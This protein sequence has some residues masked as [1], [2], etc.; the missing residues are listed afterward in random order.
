MSTLIVTDD[1][2]G[3]GR[4]LL[5]AANATTLILKD[6]NVVSSDDTAIQGGSN[7]NTVDVLVAGNIY[8]DLKGIG[9]VP[10]IA[11]TGTQTLNVMATGSVLA[12]EQAIEVIASQTT[13]TEISVSNAG[14][15]LSQNQEAV[16]I[17]GAAQATFANT[18]S[19]TGT[20]GAVK[21]T[22]LD[23]NFTNTGTVNSLAQG[24]GSAN[25]AVSFTNVSGG[26]AQFDNS[27]TV[28]GQFYSL[29]AVISDGFIGTNSGTMNG[30]IVINANIAS[31]FTNSG[32]IFGFVSLSNSVSGTFVFQNFG[33][34]SGNVN[35][36]ETSNISNGGTIGGN[37]T[38]GGED[39]VYRAVGAGVVAGTVSGGAGNDTIIGGSEADVLDGSFENDMV[40]GMAGD[41]ELYGGDGDDTLRGG[42]GEDTLFGGEGED[43][44]AGNSGNDIMTGEAGDDR[45]RGDGGD[46]TLFGGDDNDR[47]NGGSGNDE[48]DGGSGNDTIR[49]GSGADIITTTSG[50]NRLFGDDG[51]DEINGGDGND[52]IRGG[53]GNDDIDG[54]GGNDNIRGDDGNDTLFGSAGIDTLFGG[55]GDD[56]FL[57][58]GPT[59]STSTGTGDQ[60]RDF[61]RGEDLLD[62]ATVDV[63]NGLTFVGTDAFLA[64]GIGQIR[65][66]DSGNNIRVQVDVFGNGST[67]MQFTMYNI[68]ELSVEDFIL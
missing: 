2:I 40:R 41:D 18:G 57:F 64:N 22:A 12:G 20:V 27:G 61:T 31:S 44:I 4:Q 63:G 66:F 29:F 62:M 68:Q 23:S 3:T 55:A 38:M 67:D 25:A 48:L 6:V 35:S 56:V 16:L 19:V 1:Q 21:F 46:D 43:N 47:L 8:G 36:F 32:E 10:T 30:G 17:G 13:G 60:I 15:L 45:L 5:A 37:V 50:N 58:D 33:L 39:D 52:I 26:S 9:L 24:L 34:V 51:N 65:Y 54:S 53:D 11:G 28:S 14:T 49:A 59:D 42:S 7:A